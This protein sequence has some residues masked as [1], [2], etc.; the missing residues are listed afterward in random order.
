MRASTDWNWEQ[1]IRQSADDSNK[2]LQFRIFF[3]FAVAH[4]L[5][6]IITGFFYGR[7]SHYFTQLALPKASGSGSGVL[8]AIGD[9]HPELNTCYELAVECWVES[10]GWP[11]RAICVSSFGLSECLKISAHFPRTFKKNNSCNIVIF[12]ALS[13]VYI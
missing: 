9:V 4:R 8:I 7:S 10:L 1:K 3:F 13:H 12:L 2:E 6:N 11:W 5:G